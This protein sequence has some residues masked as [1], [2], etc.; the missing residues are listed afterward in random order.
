MRLHEMTR[1]DDLYS[2]ESSH[3]G[4][5]FKNRFFFFFFLLALY[6]SI[7][8]IRIESINH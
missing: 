4:C 2:V 6:L 8:E 5:V 3:L 7:G 1:D